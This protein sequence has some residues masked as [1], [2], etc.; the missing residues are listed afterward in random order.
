MIRHLVELICRGGNHVENDHDRIGDRS[1]ILFCRAA[2]AAENQTKGHQAVRRPTRPSPMSTS[3]RPGNRSSDSV[4]TTPTIHREGD[5]L[6]MNRLST[7]SAA[8]APKKSA[9]FSGWQLLK[10]RQKTLRDPPLGVRQNRTGVH[11]IALAGGS[12]KTHYPCARTCTGSRSMCGT[13][14]QLCELLNCATRDSDEAWPAPRELCVRV[15]L[16]FEVLQMPHEPI[17]LA[18]VLDQ[19][20]QQLALRHQR[21]VA[22]RI[23]GQLN[24]FLLS[25]VVGFE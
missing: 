21:A 12:R 13:G 6:G 15:Q 23:L 3:A 5:H 22:A 16:A 14:G 8:W 10:K 20:L 11:A 2:P 4:E 25:V 18:L 24:G 9:T 1:R 19:V 7:T 17:V